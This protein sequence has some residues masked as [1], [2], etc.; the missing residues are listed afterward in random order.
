V[1]HET[2]RIADVV[3]VW[4][5]DVEKLGFLTRFCAKEKTILVLLLER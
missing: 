5:N 3:T 2:R 4:H 1:I